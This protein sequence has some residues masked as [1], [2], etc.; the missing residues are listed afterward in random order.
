MQDKIF[1]QHNFLKRDAIRRYTPSN[2]KSLCGCI[3]KASVYGY[4]SV[5]KESQQL[6]TM[7]GVPVIIE[8]FKIIRSSYNT[9]VQDAF[10]SEYESQ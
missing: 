3:K 6:W 7:C 9:P 4:G 5:C 2:L 8:R 1:L 10:Y